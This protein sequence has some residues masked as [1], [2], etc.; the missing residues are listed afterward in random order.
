MTQKRKTILPRLSR[1]YQG[2][3][4]PLGHQ[5]GVKKWT[6]G[7]N[8]SKNDLD[9]NQNRQCSNLGPLEST[10]T[11]TRPKKKEKRHKWSR[12]ELKEN[13]DCFYYALEIHQKFV[14]QRKHLRYKL[15]RERNKTERLYIDPNMLASVRRAVMKKKLL[16]FRK[17]K[18]RWKQN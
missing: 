1:R 8:S 17:L 7:S 10:Q 12:E 15:W 11:D 2:A 6:T 14:Q 13:F 4:H 9:G 18:M 5:G 3:C 16:N